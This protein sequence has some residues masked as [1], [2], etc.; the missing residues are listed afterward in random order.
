MAQRMGR[1]LLGDPGL[2]RIALDDVPERLAGHAI[3]APG[4]KEKIG[5][6]LEQDFPT[7]P[8]LEVRQPVHR[9]LAERY[10]PLAVAF[11]EDADHALI[12]IHLAVTQ[13]HQLRDAQS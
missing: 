8:M 13:V 3:A 9:L 1:E 7:R 5:L 2:A 10:Q 11:A 4:R 12:E 6:P